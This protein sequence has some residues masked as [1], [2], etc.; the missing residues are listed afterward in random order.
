MTSQDSSSGMEDT[1]AAAGD[2]LIDDGIVTAV[3]WT[4]MVA[5]VSV[6]GMGIVAG[7]VLF[8]FVTNCVDITF[9]R[10]QYLQLGYQSFIE[11]LADMLAEIKLPVG[12]PTHTGNSLLISPRYL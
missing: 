4:A 11:A 5:G 9:T 1:V 12:F 6:L 8:M 3:D 7:A 2:E 10:C